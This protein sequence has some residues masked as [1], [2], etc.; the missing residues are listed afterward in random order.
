M[1]T[2]PHLSVAQERPITSPAGVAAPFPI[3]APQKRATSRPTPALPPLP[4][5]RPSDH[6]PAGDA[7]AT[8]DTKATDP[9]D[10]ALATCLTALAARGG[11]ALPVS[12]E[13]TREATG[14]CAIPGAVTFSR[15][16]A[17]GAPLVSLDSSVTI[18]CTL[19]LELSSWIRDDLA[20]IAKRHGADLAE[21][22]G[23]GGFACRPR[24][25]Q[26]GAQISEHASGNALDL[27]GLRLTDGRVIELSSTDA[28]TRT[29]REDIRNSACARFLTVLGPG[30]DSAHKS[31]VHLDMRQRRGYFR[32][33][34]WDVK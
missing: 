32:M 21:L 20:P 10:A 6:G 8:S 2:G 9:G 22:T 24:N 30:A 12:S 16:N 27:L 19:A 14:A 31:H 28:A 7:S 18:R 13:E 29:I 1:I 5:P 23:V 26:A 25:G 3:P 33:C 15:V 17:A 4:L 11:E 34:Q